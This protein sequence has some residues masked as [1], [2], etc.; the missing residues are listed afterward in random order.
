MYDFFRRFAHHVSFIAAMALIVLWTTTGSLF[1]YSDTWQFIACAATII[2]MLLMA[3][4]IRNV[5]L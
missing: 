4:L 1:G 3:L 5:E 2:T